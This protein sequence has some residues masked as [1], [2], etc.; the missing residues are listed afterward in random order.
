MHCRYSFVSFH[1][2][3]PFVHWQTV[4][5]RQL[6]SSLNSQ[7]VIIFSAFWFVVH[8]WP[9]HPAVAQSASCVHS[10]KK[11]SSTWTKEHF[12]LMHCETKG[13]LWKHVFVMH[14]RSSIIFSTFLFTAKQSHPV[15]TILQS[16]FSLQ[17]RKLLTW[18]VVIFCGCVL[19]A[20][21]ALKIIMIKKN[22]VK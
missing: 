17:L 1:L 2:H 22:A 14:T 11:S 16:S 13:F 19:D 21:P 9:E 7:V 3:L 8:I 15:Q 5:F 6:Y 18:L 12:L 20:Q 10:T 4:F